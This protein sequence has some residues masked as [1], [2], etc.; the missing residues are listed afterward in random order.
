M[1]VAN[2]KFEKKN[3]IK[4]RRSKFFGGKLISS[5]SHY[6]S[7]ARKRVREGRIPKRNQLYFVGTYNPLEEK[8]N[9]RSLVRKETHEHVRLKVHLTIEFHCRRRRAQ[10][11]AGSSNQNIRHNVKRTHAPYSSD[12]E[13]SAARKN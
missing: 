10:R 4:N 9:S 3:G 1:R 2:I 5:A 12:W 6:R 13:K 11:I 7:C 8:K